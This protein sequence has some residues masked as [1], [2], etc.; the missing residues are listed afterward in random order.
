MRAWSLAWNIAEVPVPSSAARVL[1]VR[2]TGEGCLSYL[3]GAG[4]QAAVIDAALDP[5]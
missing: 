4:G 2:R 3:V 5:V 1:Q